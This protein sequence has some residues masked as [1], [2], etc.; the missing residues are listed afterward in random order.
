MN[1]HR[2]FANIDVTRKEYASMLFFLSLCG[3]VFISFYLPATIY[4]ITVLIFV[5]LYLN[6][7][8]IQS[9]INEAAK[10]ICD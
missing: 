9:R 2:L 3:N 7:K 4:V 6:D 1:D 5:F 10:K 8:T